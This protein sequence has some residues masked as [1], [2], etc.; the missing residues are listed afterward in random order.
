MQNSFPMASSTAVTSVTSRP[1]SFPAT[2]NAISS[3]ASAAGPSRLRERVSILMNRY[4]R[5]RAPVSRFLMRGRK[6]V[7]LMLGICGLFG[8]S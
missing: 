5:A 3:P 7:F 4:G 2:P 6:Q 1:A 8:S